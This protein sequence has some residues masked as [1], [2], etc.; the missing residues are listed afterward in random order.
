MGRSPDCPVGQPVDQYL[1]RKS[2]RNP[3]K[4]SFRGVARL[5]RRENNQPKIQEG[6]RMAFDSLHTSRF[7]VNARYRSAA[8]RV[9]AAPL[10]E[11]RDRAA[12][13]SGSKDTSQTRG[14]HVLSRRMSE[15]YPICPVHSRRISPSICIVRLW[16]L[17]QSPTGIISYF[18]GPGKPQDAGKVEM[19]SRSEVGAAVSGI[20]GW[21]R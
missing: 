15:A 9:S 2:T 12:P 19:D 17:F 3:Q 6:T 1:A 11:E 21:K 5:R 7:N 4:N 8:A 13:R 10:E 20:T 16:A 18:H 14:R